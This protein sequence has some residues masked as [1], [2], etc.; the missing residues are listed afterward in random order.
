MLLLSQDEARLVADCLSETADGP[1][2]D[3]QEFE[4]LFGFTRS[5][6]REAAGRWAAGAPV[7]EDW[8][9]GRGALNNLL[10]YPHGDRA[11]TAFMDKL[12]ADE[13][14]LETLQSRM[15]GVSP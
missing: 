4:T 1:F 8:R 5:E 2:Y 3:D 14:E 12:G 10:G 15:R 13:P 7:D 11:R 9:A 6:M